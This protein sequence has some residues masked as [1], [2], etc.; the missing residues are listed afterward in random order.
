LN[1]QHKF[2][3]EQE[4]EKMMGWPAISRLLVAW[5][6]VFAVNAT[7]LPQERLPN[8]L[9]QALQKELQVDTVE[10]ELRVEV[11]RHQYAPDQLRRWGFSEDLIRQITEEMGSR[12]SSEQAH[13]RMRFDNRS[14]LFE[15][16]VD[17]GLSSSGDW[18]VLRARSLINNKATVN[19]QE[20]R[21]GEDSVR[22][23]LSRGAPAWPPLAWQS[24]TWRYRIWHSHLPRS[25]RGDLSPLTVEP[26]SGKQGEYVIKFDNVVI[27]AQNAQDGLL[28]TRYTA[29][30]RSSGYPEYE[31]EFTYRQT[32]ERVPYP[33]HLKV[34]HYLVPPVAYA[35]GLR[36]PRKTP[37][38][39]T[40][41]TVDRVRINPAFEQHAFAEGTIPRGTFVQDD[42]FEPPLIYTQ[43]NRQFG[44]QD[45]FRM[46]R[47]R[48]L[49][50]DADWMGYRPR[51]SKSTYGYLAVGLV[52]IGIALW[53]LIGAIRRHTLQ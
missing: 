5:L 4:A 53:V 20:V 32:P 38:E 28:L 16:T 34:F 39:V 30:D 8:L 36:I 9:H 22:M 3:P 21:S 45:L 19:Y 13:L 1:E 12:A 48:E 46:A 23:Y 51:P 31:E 52:A 44:E 49:L 50:Q 27:V 18:H 11:K 35:K 6:A 2:N 29:T 40:T 43:G 14:K 15:C 37:I 42:R 17:G 26:N 10:V 25:H 47:N 7:A 24:E 41:Y 33:M